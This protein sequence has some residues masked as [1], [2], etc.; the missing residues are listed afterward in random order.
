MTTHNNHSIEVIEMPSGGFEPV[1]KFIPTGKRVDIQVFDQYEHHNTEEDALSWAKDM[2]DKLSI[3][4]AETIR[5]NG[6]LLDTVPEEADLY[7]YCGEEYVVLTTN[8]V[9]T[10]KED[11]E[12]GE[13]AYFPY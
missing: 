7:L 5:D 8:D 13:E 1:V 10:R 4:F 9:I 3:P 2:I 6:E 12:L 11:N